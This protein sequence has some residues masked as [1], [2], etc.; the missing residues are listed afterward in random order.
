MLPS[1]GWLGLSYFT[2]FFSFGIFLPFWS[3]WL[4]GEGISPESI[5]LLLG[6]GMI[7]RFL[8]SLFIAPA[9]KK[10][11]STDYRSPPYCSPR[12]DLFYR[13]FLW[14]CMGVAAGGDG[15]I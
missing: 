5:G 2:Y 8:G 13:I 1:A 12:P 4:Q 11:L 14:Y 7:A 3:L 9:V 10:N 15:R 6:A